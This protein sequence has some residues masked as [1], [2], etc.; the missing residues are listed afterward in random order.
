MISWDMMLCSQQ[1]SE[2]G[3]SS[4]SK[5]LVVIHQA[6]KCHTLEGHNLNIYY[7]ENN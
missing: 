2:D 3:S 4:I 1:S 6:T 5:M 7:H